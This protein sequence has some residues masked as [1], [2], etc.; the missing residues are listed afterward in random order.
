MKL[1]S[2][3]KTSY[4]ITSHGLKY[5]VITPCSHCSGMQGNMFVMQIFRSKGMLISTRIWKGSLHSLILLG[6]LQGGALLLLVRRVG[7]RLHSIWHRH[8]LRRLL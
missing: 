1:P 6:V 2:E 5:K 7:F 8:V 3:R 4:E